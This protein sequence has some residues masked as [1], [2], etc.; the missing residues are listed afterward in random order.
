MVMLREK[1]LNQKN[2]LEKKLQKDIRKWHKK[3]VARL[4]SKAKRYGSAGVYQN[5]VTGEDQRQLEKI[6]KDHYSRAEKKIQPKPLKKKSKYPEI[7]QVKSVINDRIERI[8]LLRGK[9]S[10]KE[11]LKTLKSDIAFKTAEAE[12]MDD[13]DNTTFAR[14]FRKLIIKKLVSREPAITITE[15]NWIVEDGKKETEDV[16]AEQMA[17][18]GTKWIHKYKKS[19]VSV[20]KSVTDD[21]EYAILLILEESSER[22]G[23]DKLVNDLKK[24]V[25]RRNT[26][27]ATA[28]V[29][30]I[31]RVKKKWNSVGD[32]HT[33]DTHRMAG[34]QSPIA[35]NKPFLVGASMLMFPSDTSLGASLDEIIGC[36][37]YLT[38][39]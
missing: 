21:K 2:G 34:A 13:G 20:L 22:E 18:V 17:I 1:V 5:P 16:I 23:A 39:S 6:L 8:A 27:T 15:T 12:A 4:V 31:L 37:C 28:I 29:R 11:I 36:R 30:L 25:T 38:Y 35:M 26:S 3:I 33:R 9:V 14:A 32:S 24:S 19:I 7:E 10:V